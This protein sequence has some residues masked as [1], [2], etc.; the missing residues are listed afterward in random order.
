MTHFFIPHS[1]L[2]P[3]RLGFTQTINDA[4]AIKKKRWKPQGAD[5]E[6]EEDCSLRGVKGEL[7]YLHNK[8]T[9]KM[10]V[11]MR[12]AKKKNLHFPLHLREELE[13][14]GAKK[15]KLGVTDGGAVS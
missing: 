2:L 5:E 4:Y 10:E 8:G 7:T 6:E 14:G 1:N 9:F 13:R 11:Q 12:K 3:K 15:E